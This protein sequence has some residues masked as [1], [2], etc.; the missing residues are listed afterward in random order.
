[1]FDPFFFADNP[2]PERTNQKLSGR[3]KKQ[4]EVANM[5]V[6]N[7]FGAKIRGLRE[8]RNISAEDLSQ[9]CGLTVEEIETIEN[10]TLLPSLTPLLK[11]SRVSP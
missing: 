4:Q 11:I 1:M 5:P 10:G 2:A 6:N 8:I 9:R 3:N 7:E